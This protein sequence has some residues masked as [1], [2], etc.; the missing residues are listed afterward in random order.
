[1]MRGL[2]IAAMIMLVAAVATVGYAQTGAMT[3]D[4]MKMMGGQMKGMSD[5]MKGGKIAPDQMKMMG[6]HMQ[7]MADRM[8]DGQM[9]PEQTKMMGD[10]MKMMNEQM[11]MMGDQMKKERSSA[12]DGVLSGLNKLGDVRR[13]SEAE[14][15]LGNRAECAQSTALVPREGTPKTNGQIGDA[16]RSTSAKEPQSPEFYAPIRQTRTSLLK[17]LVP[18][19]ETRSPPAGAWMSQ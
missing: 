4:Q 1:M 9:S 8:K 17:R 12:A 16:T 7:M 11:K 6:E 2:R 10:H 13:V 3:P 14:G 15:C 18:K 5:Q 19:S